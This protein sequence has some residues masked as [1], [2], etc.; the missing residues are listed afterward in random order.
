VLYGREHWAGLIRWMRDT[1]RARGMIATADLQLLQIAESPE[2]VRDLVV[3]AGK[4][5]VAEEAAARS[6]TRRALQR[7]C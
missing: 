6:T 7:P 2:E 1:A 3:R 4:T 5:R